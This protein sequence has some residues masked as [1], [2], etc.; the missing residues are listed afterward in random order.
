MPWVPLIRLLLNSSLL[1]SL[2]KRTA[3]NVGAQFSRTR[4]PPTDVNGHLGDSRLCWTLRLRADPGA[5]N[6]LLPFEAASVPHSWCAAMLQL[7]STHVRCVSHV[8]V[9]ARRALPEHDPV[10]E[11]DLHCGESLH[12]FG[13]TTNSATVLT[14]LLG[15]CDLPDSRHRSAALRRL[16]RPDCPRLRWHSDA[17]AASHCTA[18]PGTLLLLLLLVLSNT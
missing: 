14:E 10:L 7:D 15:G 5:G 6:L 9:L 1:R 16:L 2:H 12:C 13:C 17:T 18:L 8:V 11:P 3:Y 4:T